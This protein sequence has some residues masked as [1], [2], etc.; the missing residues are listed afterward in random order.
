[1]FGIDTSL[2][3]FVLLA[4]VSAG[5]I[6]Y[7]LMFRRISDEAIIDKRLQTV[8]RAET[9]RMAVAASRDRMQE[10]AKRR[11][12][13]QDSLK[14]LENRQKAKDKNVKKP[15]LKQQL[16]QAGMTVTIAP[17]DY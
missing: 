3:L 11:K 15:P 10:A 16:R 5:A 7:A 9:D 12:T 4:G 2:L 13:V 1:M 17:E 6:A 8:K 14:D